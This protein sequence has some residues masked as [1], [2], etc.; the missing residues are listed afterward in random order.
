[1]KS[2]QPPVRL[3]MG[4]GP[5]EVPARVLQA[6][7]RPTLGHLDPAFT[8]LMDDTRAGLARAFR[9]PEHACLPLSGPGTAAMEAAM[10]N[11]L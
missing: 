1:M 10:A 5:S 9:A 2:F 3:L 7:A 11:L 4:P 6:M 8:A